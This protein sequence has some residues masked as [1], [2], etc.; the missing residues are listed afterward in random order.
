MNGFRGLR[1]A[2]VLTLSLTLCACVTTP[3]KSTPPPPQE[4]LS[5]TAQKD[6]YT[7][8]K[9]HTELAAL[10]FQANNLIVALEELTIAISIDPGYALAY[11]TR[12]VVL[13]YIQEFDSARKDFR[14]ALALDD[15]DPAINNNYGWFLCHT[16]KEKEG[17]D[18]LFRAI[19]NPLYQTPEVAYL[20]AGSCYASL[21][22][23]DAAEDAVRKSMRL[24]SE[25]PQTIYQ[26]ANILYLR[27]NADAARKY[28]TDLVRATEPNAE[29][30]WLLI[31]VERKLGNS[32]AESSLTA[33]LRR[34]FPDSPEYQ[35]L[36]KGSFE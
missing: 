27:G 18:Y 5:S 22:D 25:T 35:A 4:N 16:G 23:L 30:L 24:A 14:Q 20:N 3:E 36:L 29:I 1:M 8:A 31:R 33:Q 2:L 21:G 11:S 32:N 17:I 12:G 6:I 7:R 15:K 34:N 10:Y 19:R 26:L 13:Y 28:L 9:L